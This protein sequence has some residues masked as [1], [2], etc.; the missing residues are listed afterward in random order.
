MSQCQL[1]D[2]AVDRRLAGLPDWL[3]QR[4]PRIA[5]HKKAVQLGWYCTCKGT[6]SKVEHYHG[7]STPRDEDVAATWAAKVAAEHPQCGPRPTGPGAT[8]SLEEA[9][10]DTARVVVQQVNQTRALK[11]QLTEVTEVNE[12]LQ[13]QAAAAEVAVGKKRTADKKSA[14]DE[15]R[16]LEIDPS[17][18]DLLS[19]TDI[20]Y[21]KRAPNTGLVATVKYWA[22]GSSAAVFQLV[23]AL[24]L[25]FNLQEQLARQGV[26]SQVSVLLERSQNEKLSMAVGITQVTLC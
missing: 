17:C 24:V 1:V 9:L 26:R 6:L 19:D 16:R 22:R 11:R 14:Q 25:H 18:H 8:P 3:R 2:F 10:C 4:Q 15:G 13:G 23:W 21:A 7:K 12:Q 5:Q 20:S